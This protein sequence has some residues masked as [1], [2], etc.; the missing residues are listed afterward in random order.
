M[1]SNFLEASKWLHEDNPKYGMASEYEKKGSMKYLLT[2][3]KAV[4]HSHN[5]FGCTSLLDHGTGK[6]GLVHS[7]KKQLQDKL[8]I[9]GYDPAVEEYSTKP[10]D[11]YDIVTSVDVLEHIGIGEIDCI[12]HEISQLTERFF[13]FCIDLLPAT[14]RTKDNRNAHFLIAPSDWW[15]QKIKNQFKIVTSVEAGEMDDGSRYPMHLL[16]CASNSMNHYAEMSSFLYNIKA[17]TVRWVFNTE[18]GGVI[19]K[20][21]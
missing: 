6:G 12:L 21:Y 3:P 20:P 10:I 16:G 14:K 8:K 5:Q 2:L 13:F 1:K 19:F 9:D 11:R 15:I 17:A 7:I 18:L 4:S